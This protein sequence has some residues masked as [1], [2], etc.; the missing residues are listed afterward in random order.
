LA[1]NQLFKWKIVAR[2]TAPTAAES[3]E[4][5]QAFDRFVRCIWVHL[6]VCLLGGSLSLHPG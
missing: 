3:D 2:E 4:F 6:M 1:F 5:A